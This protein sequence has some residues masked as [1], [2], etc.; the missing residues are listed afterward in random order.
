MQSLTGTFHPSQRVLLGP[1]PSDVP[2]RVLQ[3]M[4]APTLG[5]LDPEYLAL[6]D[7]TRKQLQAVFRTANEM[8]LAV[9]GTGSAG[10]EA[11]VVNLVEPGDE[12]IV[13]VNGVFGGRM[14]DVMERAG[15][16]VHAIEVPWGE[17]VPAERVE[18][19]LKAHP[20]SPP[21]LP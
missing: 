17:V 15:A 6:M 12:V 1:G 19:A 13:C 5:H 21:V 9:S 8:T 2:A 18:A 16:V 14:K 20:G 4:A 3:A 7:D 10:M 11:V